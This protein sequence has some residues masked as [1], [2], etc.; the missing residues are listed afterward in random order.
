M[1]LNGTAFGTG[2]N[3]VR[4]GWKRNG[5]ELRTG[6]LTTIRNYGNILVYYIK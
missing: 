2:R 5:M 4:G 6:P 3:L 1:G